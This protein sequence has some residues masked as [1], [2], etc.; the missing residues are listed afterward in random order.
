MKHLTLAEIEAMKPSTLHCIAAS[1]HRFIASSLLVPKFGL[2]FF[3]WGGI[4]FRLI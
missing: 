3:R 1:L 4:C 2:S